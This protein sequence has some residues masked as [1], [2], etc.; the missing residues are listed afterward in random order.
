[1]DALTRHKK[2]EHREDIKPPTIAIKPKKSG[3]KR[4][5]SSLDTLSSKNKRLKIRK[6]PNNDW[7]SGDESEDSLLTSTKIP[8]KPLIPGSSYSQ[9]RIAK[10]QLFYLIRENE[11][12]Q[13]EYESS[14]KKLR[15]M[16]TERKVLLNAVMSAE[17][18]SEDE[19]DI[20]EDL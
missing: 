5:S 19:A 8:S 11:M 16:K 9:Y 14:Q 2:T 4:M 13:E 12:L 10:A 1:M 18:K 17:L 6:T 3:L 15:R 7:S 20:P